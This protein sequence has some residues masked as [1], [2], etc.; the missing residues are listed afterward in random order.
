MT[1]HHRYVNKRNP[2]NNS[3][4]NGIQTH[5]LCNTGAVPYQLSYQTNWELD[6]L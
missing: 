6:I 2:E 5:D 3:G 1:D 4:L